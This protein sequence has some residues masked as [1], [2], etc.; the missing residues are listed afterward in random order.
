MIWYE[1]FG[2]G[3]ASFF[4]LSAIVS[5]IKDHVEIKKKSKGKVY[6]E[7]GEL[8]MNGCNVGRITSITHSEPDSNGDVIVAEGVE[9]RDDFG[10]MVIQGPHDPRLIEISFDM[11]IADS[12]VQKKTQSW[13]ERWRK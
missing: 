2:I 4:L 11:T 3:M 6:M 1:W 8:F 9:L 5:S 12:P 13:E 10:V 7:N